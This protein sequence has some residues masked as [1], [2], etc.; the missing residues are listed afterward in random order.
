MWQCEDFMSFQGK[1]VL[2][3]AFLV[4]LSTKHTPDRR[5][6]YKQH[7]FPELDERDFP[8]FIIILNGMRTPVNFMRNE[9]ILYKSA[10]NSAFEE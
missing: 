1:L 5:M 9:I 2:F 8:C 10:T 3:I 4:H 6:Y 7:F